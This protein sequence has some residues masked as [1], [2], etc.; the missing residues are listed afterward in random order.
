METP[1]FIGGICLNTN[2]AGCFDNVRKWCEIEQKLPPIQNGPHSV[3]ILGCSGGYGLAARSVAAFGAGAHTFGVS[4]ERKPTVRRSA[5]PGWYNNLAFD[6][7]AAGKQLFSE[8]MD[9]DAF[10]DA[11]REA[12]IARVREAGL[13]PF[14]LVVYSLAAPQRTDPLTGTIHHSV[15]K[16]VGAP[17]KGQTLDIPTNKLIEVELQP[18]TDK[19]IADTVKVMGGEDWLRWMQVLKSEKLLADGVKTVAFSYIGPESTYAVYRSGTLG[20]AKE[21]LEATASEIEKLL[22]D[23]KGRAW[24]AVCKALITRASSVIPVMSVYVAVMYRIMKN[25]GLHEGCLEQMDR[26]FR[27]RLYTNGDVPVD[28]ANRI[29]LDDWEM[30]PKVQE[31][32]SKSLAELT[33]DNLHLK[34]DVAGCAADLRSIYGF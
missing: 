19:E 4:L 26:L 31:K 20:K 7:E 6:M 21:H 27:E 34:A 28:S 2:P 10:S 15:I 11:T 8:T 30:D 14:D 24:V 17:L 33:A 18:A 16:P 32:I 1:R 13:P 5:A 9:A 29:R 12:A 23:Q 3:L 25:M 22:G